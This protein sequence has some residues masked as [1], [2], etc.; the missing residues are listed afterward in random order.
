MFFFSNCKFLT[1]YL[2]GCYLKSSRYSS[3]SRVIFLVTLHYSSILKNWLLYSTRVTVLPH[4]STLLYSSN[5]ISLLCPTLN[6]T[7]QREI[8][9]KCRPSIWISQQTK[10]IRPLKLPKPTHWPSYNIKK[11]FLQVFN[12]SPLQVRLSYFIKIDRSPSWPKTKCKKWT[13]LKGAWILLRNTISNIQKYVIQIKW[14]LKM[15]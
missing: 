10:Q 6:I 11:C 14:N 9:A 5:E 8:K 15:K 4:Y 1:F 2:S 13:Q 12:L 3:Y 7:H